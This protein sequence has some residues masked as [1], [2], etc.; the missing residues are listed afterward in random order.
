[1]RIDIALD[2]FI[3]Q[4]R[5]ALTL[6]SPKLLLRA[7]HVSTRFG[8]QRANNNVIMRIASTVSQTECT[9]STMA[10]E[11]RARERTASIEVHERGAA[12]RT[13]ERHDLLAHMSERRLDRQLVRRQLHQPL[14]LGALPLLELGGHACLG[15]AQLAGQHELQHGRLDLHAQLAEFKARRHSGIA[16]RMWPPWGGA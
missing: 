13:L 8:F 11:T 3:A 12:A 15:D 10:I 16:Q 9:E 6:K 14:D 5:A 2:V 4:S 7:P 1:M